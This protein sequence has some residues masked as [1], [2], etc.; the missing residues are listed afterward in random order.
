MGMKILFNS[1]YFFCKAGNIDTSTCFSCQPQLSCVCF[2]LLPVIFP[3]SSPGALSSDF[4]LAD[5][6]TSPGTFNWLFIDKSC[7]WLLIT[8][9]YH[10]LKFKSAMS[11]SRNGPFQSFAA[12]YERYKRSISMLVPCI[13]SCSFTD[14][15]PETIWHMLQSKKTLQ[16]NIWLDF[17]SRCLFWRGIE[18]VLMGFK[19]CINSYLHFMLLP[20]KTWAKFNQFTSCDLLCDG[21]KSDTL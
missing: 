21:T 12:V 15:K 7:N 1:I 3:L 13:T 4:A 9:L 2:Q 19:A 14:C 18:L 8:S 5:P 16:G 20:E 6:C 17:F 11:T 10:V